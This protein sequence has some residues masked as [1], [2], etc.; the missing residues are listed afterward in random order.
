MLNGK[1]EDDFSE[2]NDDELN[3]QEFLEKI[4]NAYQVYRVSEGVLREA[5]DDYG[6]LKI[7][8]LGVEFAR[9]EF[10][11]LLKE[12]QERGIELNKM[13]LLE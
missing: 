7:A 5:G 1:F 6:K 10:F 13:D 4:E 8:K 12:A 11:T 3:H 2:V 9:H